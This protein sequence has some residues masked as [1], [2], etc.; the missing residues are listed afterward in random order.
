MFYVYS[1]AF[2][3]VQ[4]S[5]EIRCLGE[6]HYTYEFKLPYVQDYSRVDWIIPEINGTPTIEEFFDFYKRIWEF[7]KAKI[8]KLV[9]V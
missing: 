4:H 6:F 3:I 1:R 5:P 7:P 8:K 2:Q 9:I